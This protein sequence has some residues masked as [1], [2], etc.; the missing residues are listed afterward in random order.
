MRGAPQSGF[1][2]AH[3]ANQRPKVRCQRRPTDAAGSRL[4][5]PIGSERAPMPTHDGGG[6]HDLHRPPPVRPDAREQHPEQPIDRTKA[7]SFRGGPLEH[8]ELMPERENFRRE[9]EP[10]ADRGSKRG[11]QGDEQRSH[12]ARE[13]YQSLARNR[14]GLN[15]YGIFSRDRRRVGR[16]ATRRCSGATGSDGDP[17]GHGLGAPRGR[18][19]DRAQ[20]EVA[21]SAPTVSGVAQP[22]PVTSFPGL[23]IDPAISPAGN[24]VAFAWDGEGEDNFD[25]YVGS[26]DGRSQVQLTSDA[27]PDHLPTWSPDGQRIAFVR[28]LNGRRAIVE[29]PALG[30]PETGPVRGRA[31]AWRSL[32]IGGTTGAS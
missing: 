17:R 16:Y 29:V 4:P 25:I 10:R 24:L 19:L 1:A 20:T 2:L 3:L 5:A 30:G 12:P 32:P 6:R 21:C 27:A 22:V 18:S 8:G 15:R 14:N 23:E 13:R 31:R 7:R 11:Q 9:L 26:L 28:V